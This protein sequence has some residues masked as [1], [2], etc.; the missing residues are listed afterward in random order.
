MSKST[1]TPN[2]AK[3]NKMKDARAVFVSM[4]GEGKPRKD[5]IAAFQSTCSLSAA[6]AATY[7]QTL[8][9]EAETA[10]KS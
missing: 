2:T 8:K 1:T 6:G 5:I 7:Y 3:L 9:K 4:S 10:V